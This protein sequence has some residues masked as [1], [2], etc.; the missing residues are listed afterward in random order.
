MRR[1]RSEDLCFTLALRAMG[2][3]VHPLDT[4]NQNNDRGAKTG[5]AKDYKEKATG[6][7]RFV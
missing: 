6:E 2:G 5:H 4:L 3:Y 7:N 1:W